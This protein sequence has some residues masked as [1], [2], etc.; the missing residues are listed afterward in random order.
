MYEN[1]DFEPSFGE[2]IDLIKQYED[3][4][5]AKQQLFF[6]EDSYEQIIT[7]YQE[8]RELNKAMQVADS[9]LEQY[10]YSAFFI[11]KKAEVLAEQK[12][13][14]E[15][16]D[17][18]D[19]AEMLDAQDINIYLIRADIFLWLGRHTEALEVIETAL[20]I[21]SEPEDKTELYLEMADVYEDLEKYWE[22]I[23]ALKK[24]IECNPNSEEALNRMWFCTELTEKYNDSIEFHEALIEKYP[25]NLLAWFN[26]GHAHA[27]LKKYDDAL[28]AFGYAIAIDENF[29]PAYI[30]TADVLYMAGNYNESLRFYLDAIKLSKPNK[31]LYLK[32]AECFEKLGELGKSRSYLRKA[33]AVDPYYDEAFYRIG[34][35]YRL[36]EKWPKAISSFERAVKLSKDNVD[37]LTALADAYI[38]IDEG[39]KALDLFIHIF[40]IDPKSKQNWVNLATAYFNME[41]FRKAFQIL[42]EAEQKYDDCA[43]ILY[44]KAVF[45]YQAGNK[46][47]ALL[48]LEKGLLL[49]YDEH[50]IIFEMD[51]NLRNDEVVMQIID[52]Y[53]DRSRLN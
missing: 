35:T 2:I 26:L 10:P 5:K 45:Y 1:E 44:I 52:Q 25:Y 11:T 14:D 4:V 39:Q 36:E 8:N 53:Q 6:E 23:D 49:S 3:A 30:C 48:N 19:R 20:L 43:D 40:N 50:Y 27:G 17:Y 21:G 29:E 34:E 9:A 41:D 28:E 12:M 24:A 37:Y 31:E 42:T 16:L 33:I 22:V 13:F 38:S 46:N 7:F 47:E 32:T 18:L 15:A 51:E